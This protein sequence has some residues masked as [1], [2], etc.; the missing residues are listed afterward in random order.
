MPEKLSYEEFVR[1]AI[2][3]LRKEGYKGVFS[4]NLYNPH[5]FWGI[6]GRILY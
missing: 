5:N 2:V 3:S 6:R 1:K 4:A